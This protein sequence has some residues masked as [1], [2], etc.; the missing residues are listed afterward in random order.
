MNVKLLS[1][2]G[3]HEIAANL[4]IGDI[5]PTSKLNDNERK[6]VVVA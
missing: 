1:R 4:E 3:R 2:W 6:N 5:T